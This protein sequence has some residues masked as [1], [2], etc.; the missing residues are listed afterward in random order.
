[1]DVRVDPDHRGKYFAI[2]CKE[3]YMWLFKH[4]SST[5]TD[6]PKLRLRVVDEKSEGPRSLCSIE[7]IRAAAD[8]DVLAV[9][10]GLVES[11]ALQ[12]YN[13]LGDEGTVN[14]SMIRRYVDRLS[15]MVLVMR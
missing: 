12:I 3:T 9:L 14:M 13:I 7:F 1:M 2:K 11:A 15:L 6:L 5:D 4:S 8:M 10:V